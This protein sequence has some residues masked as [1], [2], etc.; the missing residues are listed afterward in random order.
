[1]PTISNVQLQ[2]QKTPLHQAPTASRTVTVNYQVT[3][4]QAEVNA[5]ANFQVRVSLLSNDNN[6]LP[7]TTFNLT[8]AAGPVSR[9]ETRAFERRQL[10]EDTDSI[11]IFDPQGHPHKI[12]LEMPDMWRAR[13]MVIYVPEPVFGNATNISGSVTGSWGAQGDD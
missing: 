5:R 4:N 6:V 3:F 8:A 12:P 2:I 7:I 1:M 10:D 11:I 9:T 13:V